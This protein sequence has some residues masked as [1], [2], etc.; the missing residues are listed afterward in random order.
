MFKV[1]FLICSSLSSTVRSSEGVQST[2]DEETEEGGPPSKTTLSGEHGRHSRAKSPEQQERADSP[3]PSC[4]S[5]KSDWSMSP[6]LNFKD[7][8][9]SVEKRRVQQERADSP[10]PSCV[11]MK[12]DHSMEQ[13][14]NF[15]D[16]SQSVEKRR[17]QERADS[18]GPSCVSMKSDRSMEHPVHFEDGN[19]SVEKRHHQERSKVPSAQSVQQYPTELIQVPAGRE[20][21]TDASDVLSEFR[22]KF[23]LMFVLLQRAEED[24]HAFLDKELKKLWRG[25]F[26]DYP[27]CSESQR[28]EEEEV[29]DGEEEEQ[30]RR[31]IEGVRDITVLCL[32]QLKQEELADS[33][34]SSKHFAVK[35]QPKLKSHLKEK[36]QHVFEGVPKAGQATDLN[37]IYTEIFITEGG[38]GYVN[39]EHEVRLIETASR[40]PAKEETPIKCEDIL[41]PLPGHDQPIRTIMTTGVAGIGKTVLTRK[42]TLDWAE[43][44][45]NQD[46]HF[47]FPFTFRELNLLEGKEFSLVGLLHHFFIETK[48]AGICRYERL[49]VVFILDGLDEC[50]LPLDFQKNRIWTDV[51]APTSVDVLLT[52]LIR[53]DLLPSARIWITTRPAAANRIPAE[54]V[55]MV[56]EVRGFTNPQKKEYFRKRFSDETLARKI[57]SHVK[58]S[59]SLHIMCH[60]PVF[61]WISATVMEDI[62]T[63]SQSGEEMPN[64]VTQMYIHFLRVQSIQG[65][66]KYHGRAEADPH[67]SSESKEII[68][69]LGKLAFNQ[70]EKGNLIFYQADLEECGIDIRAASVYSGVF[71]Q[72][73]KEECGLYQDKVFCF[74]HLS[75]QEFLAALHV[76]LT[77]R[78][79]GVNLL[80]QEQPTSGEDD[81]LLYQSA[82]DKALLSENGHLDLFLRFLLGLSL[83]TNQILIQGL[84]GQ[85]ASSSQTSQKTVSYIKEKISGDLSPE[86]SINLFHCLNEL[87]DRSLVEEIQQYLTS[88]SLSRA[89]LS[90]GQWSAL[91]FILLTSEEE[92]DVFDL[93][94]YSASEEALL[95][96]LPVVKASKTSLLNG[97]NLSERCC[98]ALASVLSS[99]SSSL[100]ELDLSTN[101]L[102][103]SG[104]KLL[105]AGLGSP[106]CRLETLRLNGCHLSERGCEALASVL[107]SNSS[108]LRELDLSTND[109]QDSGVKLLS[110]G[111]GSPHCRLETLRL[112][113]CMVTQEGCASLASALSS[114]PSHLR[115]LD[116]SYNH[117][118]GDSG[119]TLLSA[120]L[121]DPGWRLDTLRYGE[122]SSPL[123]ACGLTL[124][125]NTAHRELSLSEDHRKVMWAEEDQSHPDHP[126]RFDSWV[127]VLCREG[128]TGRCYWEVERRG[129]V[130]IGVT[131]RG[132]R[133][134][135]GGDDSRLGWNNKSWSLNCNGDDG[136]RYTVCYNGSITAIRLP[137]SVPTRV[138][139]YVDRPAGSLSF[140][141][142]S[143]GVGG[144]SHTLTHLHTFWTTFTQEDLLPAFGFRSG[145]G[146]GS[147]ETEEGGPPSKTTL[148]GEHGRHSRAKR[149]KKEKSPEQQERADSP[150]PSC[151][152]MKSDRSMYEPWNFKDGNQSVE[153]RRVQQERADSPGPSCVSMKS[154]RSMDKPVNFKDGNQSVEK[155]RHQERSKV[156][157]AQSVQ[158]YPTELIQVCKAGRESRTDAS[159]VLSEFRVK[160]SLMFVLLQRAEEDAHAFLDKELKKLWRGHFPDYPQCSESQR[161]EEEEEEVVDGEEEEQRRRAIEGVRDITVLCLKQLK[162]EELADS[163]QS[164]KHFAAK[165]Q[166]KLKSHLKEKTQHVFE[167]VPKAGQ[168][169]DL[170]EIY[171]EIFITEGGSGDVNQEHEVRLIETASRKPAKEETPIKCEDILKPLPGQDQPIRTI[172]TTGV[173]GIGKTILTHKFTLDWA[174]GKANQ[175][176]DFTFPFTFRELNL[177][178]GKEFSLVGLLHH[179]FIETKEAGI[180][181]Y[182]RFQVVFILDGLDECRLP[183]DF[184]K[185]Q[186]WTDVTAPTSV[187]VLLTN[188]IRGD[189]LP[190][191]RI[192]ITTR[193]GAA[194]QIPAEC[195]G[196]V[197]EVRGFTDPQKEEYFRKR[198]RKKTLARKI[199]S[200]VKKSRSLHIMCHIPVFCW[201]SATVMEDFFTTSQRGEEMPNTVTQMYIHFL[202]VQ[203]I[204][205]D[206]KYH[207]RAEADPHWSSESKEI[208]VSLGKLAFN[209][210]EK[211]NLIFYQADLE[212]CGIDIRAASVY[213]GVF[214]QI[215]K[216]ECGLYQ[217]K[218]FC[219]VHLSFQEFL[220]ALHVFLSFRNTGVNLLSPEQPTSGEDDLLY[221]SAVDKALLSENG[222][223]DLFL[224]FLLGLSLETNQIPLQ[225]LL[226]QTGSSSLTNQGTVS[227]IKEKMS[228]NLSPERSIN[229]FHCLN[230]LKDRSLVEEI[231]QYLTSGSLSRASLSPGQWSA[232]VFILLT[233]EEELDVFDLKKYSASEEALL[234]LLPVVKAS[235]TSLLN[236]CHLSERGCEA[237]ASVLSS[238]S[239]SLRELD[240]STNDLQDSGVKLLSAG[241]GSPHCRLETLSLSGCMVTQEGCASLASALSSNP[242]HLRELDLSYNHPAG[243]SGVTLL[244]A[245][246]EDP[247]WRLDTLSVEHGGVGRLRPALRKCKCLFNACGLTLDPNT[248]GRRLSLSEDHMEVMEVEE[249]Q[250]HPDHPE[251]FDSWPQVLC[252]EGLTGRCYWEVERRGTVAIG[253]TYRG[254]TRRGGGHD[255]GLGHNNKSWCL[256][257]NDDGVYSV[258]YNGIVTSIRLPPPVPTRVGVFVDRPAG[259]LSFYTVSPGVGGSSHTLTHIHTFWTTFTQEDLLPGFR[260]RSGFGPGSSVSLCGL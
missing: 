195:V 211:G 10:G 237:L 39:Q 234:R 216:E 63:T 222:H 171:T 89:S 245:G 15:K 9:Q 140:Y 196:M 210:L 219:F 243:D 44:K 116:L 13:P 162:Q 186:I 199:I 57:I 58:K 65:D 64:T 113:G 232:L 117:P 62:F 238:N 122:D 18:P 179:F 176:I 109:L 251:R 154:D 4:V 8:N 144:S 225:G 108:S 118:A 5:M 173:A 7:G 12:S 71:T 85:T 99:N 166:P 181:R 185:N 26:P 212:E 93:K 97:C 163:L 246:L 134:R 160:F 49:Q 86:R 133:R 69:S 193:P 6:P 67:W 136:D 24:A 132:I 11:S 115:E 68:V 145:S 194:N 168:A 28:E 164:S 16:G 124:D 100:R 158:Q 157:S 208:I 252:R 217:D 77:F 190:S 236:G 74:V 90:P 189:L 70:L 257:C 61:C 20:S 127:Q 161:E 167:G 48:E 98:E 184:Q 17:V 248:A 111:L 191:A 19:Q 156:T 249:D 214:T 104:V 1:Y 143:P 260:F 241:L 192:W 149:R 155:R 258:R 242:S 25:H 240:L 150:G 79:T 38:S 235:K 33:L 110:A 40:K 198:F 52:N 228:G 254:I 107:S 227:Y 96:L 253:V 170:N 137:P 43:G 30:R 213:S 114:N 2:M 75:F 138:G 103:D 197:T 202:R 188:L 180:C 54:C 35:C 66:R 112:S 129:E 177:L 250:S 259:S 121:E 76:F 46:I 206:R 255:S 172:M 102:Q 37:K 187:D 151:V 142:V 135:G 226:G 224:R 218:V 169:T 72:I 159:D 91:V 42:F 73:F 106:H 36:T 152:S 203:S 119:V 175:D 34:Q 56:T 3:G 220:A 126:E 80:S 139:V 221:Q 141:R 204:Q 81:L 174:E 200:H 27:Q 182:E 60:I 231:Q 215:F 146:S 55:G 125:L 207:G 183:L 223:L 147:S 201:I 130:V 105:S 101:D 233:S 165:C 50:R 51:T 148:S 31:A 178:E 59:R 47:T 95:R 131:Y 209:Q 205:A 53:G 84:L 83:E 153:K 230:E 94:K 32:K 41:K 239:S 45:A 256:N 229:L 88:G 29:V 14:F 21:R 87:K 22:V 244:S 92:L 23:S 120:G 128:L 82:V 78:N 123:N 247:G